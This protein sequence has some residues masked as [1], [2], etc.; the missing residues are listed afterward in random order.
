MGDYENKMRDYYE[1]KMEYDHNKYSKPIFGPDTTT[2]NYTYPNTQYFSYINNPKLNNIDVNYNK[3]YLI[4]F[5][6]LILI[7]GGGIAFYL[8]DNKNEHYIRPQN[9]RIG[10]IKQ[11]KYKSCNL[12]NPNVLYPINS[13][14]VDYGSKFPDNCKCGD[15]IKSP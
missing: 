11:K 13:L 4:L 9:F 14:D 6:I 3:L 12:C 8:I 2:K 1:N 7:I 10:K 15:F 5:F